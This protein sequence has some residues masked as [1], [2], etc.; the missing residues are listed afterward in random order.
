LETNWDV[1]IVGA[2]AA[3]MSAAI[4]TCR[5]K[6]KTLIVSVDIGGQ[7]L[8]TEQEENYPGYLEMSGPK[9]MNIFQ[10][11]ATNFGAEF[12]SGKANRIEKSDGGFKVTLTN[13]ETYSANAVILAYGKVARSLGVPGEDKF[14]GRGVHTCATC[15]APFMKGR[16]VAVA[17][18]GNSAFEA[19]EL[20]SKFATKVYLIHRR[21]EFRADPITVDKVKATPNIEVIVNTEIK[22]IKGDEKVASLSVEDKTGEK[23]DIPLDS[24]FVE[25]GYIL[26]T[27]WLKGFVDL[28]EGGE[29]VVNKKCETSVPGIFAAGD[30]TDSPYKQTIVSAGEGATAALS[31]YNYFR[32]KEGKPAIKVDWD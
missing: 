9:L 23:R 8:L 7:N 1:I 13:G 22:E 16:T 2:G 19:A 27:E 32:A 10:Q 17:G 12:L 5:K 25:I 28:N 30:V 24:L 20:L 21:D 31:A 11:Q 3:G 15:D 26:D 29:I 6:M 4:Y 18:G 14:I